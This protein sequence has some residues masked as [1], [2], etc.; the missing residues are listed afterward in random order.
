M[1]E[2]H[3]TTFISEDGLEFKTKDEC[4]FWEKVADKVTRV[5]NVVNC[6]DLDACEED[7]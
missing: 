5:G 3:S 1:K 4:L 6:A 2:K 7:G